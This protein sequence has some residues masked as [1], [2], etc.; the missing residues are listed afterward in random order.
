VVTHIKEVSEESDCEK[1]HESMKTKTST[2]AKSS[3]EGGRMVVSSRFSW[4]K[5][6]LQHFKLLCIL[7]SNRYLGDYIGVSDGLLMECV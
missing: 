7:S 3:S 6:G 1:L 4:F 2:A 5:D